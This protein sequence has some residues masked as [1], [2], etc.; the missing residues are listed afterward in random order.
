[1]GINTCK[2]RWR[3]S[4]NWKWALKICN[5]LSVVQIKYIGCIVCLCV[6]VYIFSELLYI[7]IFIA[8]YLIII[9]IESFYKITE[10]INS[11]ETLKGKFILLAVCLT[12]TFPSFLYSHKRIKNIEKL[13]ENTLF[14][15]WC[16]EKSWNSLYILGVPI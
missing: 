3:M 14:M 15:K 8:L 7:F 10:A 16:N 13:E 11:T 1:M 4:F 2:L 12:V 9:F 6:C 5:L